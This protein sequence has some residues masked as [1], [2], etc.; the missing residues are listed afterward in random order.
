MSVTVFSQFPGVRP[1]HVRFVT[2]GVLPSSFVPDPGS[3]V[4]TVVRQYIPETTSPSVAPLLP[5]PTQPNQAFIVGDTAYVTGNGGWVVA[6][7]FVAAQSLPTSPSDGMVYR[8]NNTLHVYS[9]AQGTWVQYSIVGTVSSPIPLLPPAV[10]EGTIYLINDAVYRYTNNVWVLVGLV[11]GAV[12][13]VQDLP[14]SPPN[15]TINSVGDDIYQFSNSAW[16]LIGTSSGTFSDLSQVPSAIPVGE[17]YVIGNTVYVYSTSGWVSLG[18]I[19][20]TQ[21]VPQGQ[22]NPTP[23]PVVNITLAG[24]VPSV[25]DLPQPASF[26]TLYIVQNRLYAY[27]DSQWRDL[28]EAPSTFVPE[29]IPANSTRPASGLLFPRG[30]N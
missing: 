8:I 25:N 2:T 26:G 9:A 22:K 23:V 17:F 30:R 14:A 16:T 21:G 7:V 27:V 12:A 6:G 1:V 13:S 24:V 11:N 19:G 10:P 20:S 5:T 15:N 3:D 29:Q 4:L 18:E 28:G